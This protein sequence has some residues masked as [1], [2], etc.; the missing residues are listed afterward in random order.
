MCDSSILNYSPFVKMQK[1]PTFQQGV[2]CY[3]SLNS[4]VRSALSVKSTQTNP[5]LVRFELCWNVLKCFGLFWAVLGCLVCF[6]LFWFVLDCF[7]L[8][9]IVLNW[10]D[11]FWAVLGCFGLFRVVLGCFDL[12]CVAAG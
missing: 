8:F 10:F 5:V 7:R 1:L 4:K 2:G 11:I 6:G 12:F 3:S 9:R